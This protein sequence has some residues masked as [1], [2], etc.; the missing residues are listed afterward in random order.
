[1]NVQ[2]PGLPPTVFKSNGNRSI[3][4]VSKRSNASAKEEQ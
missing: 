4:N 1:M 2:S 3:S